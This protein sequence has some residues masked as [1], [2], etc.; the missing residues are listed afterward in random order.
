[1]QSTTVLQAMGAGSAPP[2]RRAVL[3]H[4]PLCSFFVFSPG[5]AFF[6][7]LAVWG[8]GLES[9]LEICCYDDI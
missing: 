5:K 7:V 6:T 1:M 4:P 3:R 2:G 9:S 8:V